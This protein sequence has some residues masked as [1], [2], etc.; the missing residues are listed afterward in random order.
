[1]DDEE[2]YGG[3]A[4]SHGAVAQTAMRR[5]GYVGAVAR[6]AL[7]ASISSLA[8]SVLITTSRSP[9]RASESARATVPS[10]ARTMARALDAVRQRVG[11]FQHHD[12][13]SVSYW[14]SVTCSP[15]VTGLSVSSL[16]LCSMRRAGAR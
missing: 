5:T 7:S 2:Q 13:G 11:L 1:M 16:S 8:A 10:P 14:A 4:P 3:A 6:A 9:L 12:V 15:H